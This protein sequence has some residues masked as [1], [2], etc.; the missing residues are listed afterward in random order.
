MA[1]YFEF[2]KYGTTY[3]KEFV[4]GLTT[5]LAMAYILAV[6]PG[7]LSD[8]TG[9]EFGEVFTAT[10]VA[11][12]I[13]TLVMGIVAKFPI[14]LAPGMGLNAFFAYTVVS[15]FGMGIPW[16]DALAGVFISGLIFLVLSFTGI[17]ETIINAI[18]QGLKYAVAAGI[19]L[20]IAFIGL[21]N[22]GI[23]VA[24][25]GT[26]VALGS[27]HDGGVL[28]ALFGI[29]VTALLMARRINGGIFYGIV[30][31]AIVGMIF[32]V[33]DTPSAI[34]SAPP[35]P[36]AFGALFDPLFSIEFWTGNMWIVILTFLFVDFFDTAG[37]LVGV[38]NQAGLMKD[39]KLPRAGRALASDSV[40]TMAGAVMGTSTT[41]S[42]IESSAGVAAGGRTGFAAVVTAGFFAL[43]L[44]F[45]PVLAVIS[46]TVTAAALVMVG[47]LMASSLGKIEWEKIDEAIPAFITV[48]AMPLT[49]SIATG[50]AMGF[51]LYPLTKLVKGEGGKVHWTM[52]V[53]FVV[54]LLYFIWLREA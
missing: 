46:G 52:Y 28:L 38:A 20:F 49:Y 54:F 29:V 40:A 12:I 10:A 24:D 23:V 39:N 44:F 2:A 26:T 34:V 48:L 35:S 50:I 41:T 22:A 8:Q 25:P 7:M 33:V 42:Y 6:N 51:I 5:F 47:V 31:T 45:S 3:R 21:K 4:A 32:G 13:G 16:Q 53:L 9:L 14:A 11:A 36:T 27:F 1:R 30:I 43:A 19:G 37:T 18:P 17:R 15:D